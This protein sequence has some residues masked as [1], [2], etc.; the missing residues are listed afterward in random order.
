ML[1]DS[2]KVPVAS[3]KCPFL[4][5]RTHPEPEGKGQHCGI[6]RRHIRDSDSINPREDISDSCRMG[7][8]EERR[9]EES[10]ETNFRLVTS[11]PPEESTFDVLCV[12]SSRF[13][14]YPGRR[15]TYRVV[16]TGGSHLTE[17]PTRLHWHPCIDGAWH[18]AYSNMLHRLT[19]SSSPIHNTH[20]TPSP[21]G[22]G[23]IRCS[24]SSAA[25]T[26]LGAA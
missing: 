14:K 6:C 7:C 26:V 2:C 22:R 20:A 15:N 21:E 24:R 17:G 11:T 19:S 9:G 1:S 23:P 13:A 18:R 16:Y 5:F 12:P 8:G 10:C 25:P 4:F 3:D